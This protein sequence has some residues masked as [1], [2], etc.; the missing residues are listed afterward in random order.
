VQ[1]LTRGLAVDELVARQN[2]ADKEIF[3]MIDDAE[4]DELWRPSQGERG[5]CERQPI[6]LKGRVWLAAFLIRSGRACSRLYDDC[7]EPASS[8]AQRTR[9]SRTWPC[10]K[11]WNPFETGSCAGG[12]DGRRRRRKT[13]KGDHPGSSS[14]RA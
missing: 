6:T 10:A 9:R 8:S 7:F 1:A 12:G 3:I 2:R 14:R 13:L 5:F 11:I 4:Y